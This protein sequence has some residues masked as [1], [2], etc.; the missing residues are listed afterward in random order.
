VPDFS[1]AE[2]RAVRV[3]ISDSL[4]DCE[5]ALVVKRL[6]ADKFGVQPEMAG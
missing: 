6:Q 3:G 4:H 1:G 2:V 5:M